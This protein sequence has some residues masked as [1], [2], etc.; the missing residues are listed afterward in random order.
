MAYGYWRAGKSG[1]DAVFHLFFRDEPFAG[2]YAIAAGLA[3]ALDYLEGLRFE[4]DDLEY[5]RAQKGNDGKPLFAGEFLDYLREHNRHPNG[6]IQERYTL[7]LRDFVF[8]NP[9]R[10]LTSLNPDFEAG[11]T[12]TRPIYVLVA[13]S[14]E[15]VPDESGFERRR[16]PLN[17]HITLM[18][19]RYAEIEKY[20][21][22]AANMY[23][24]M[25]ARGEV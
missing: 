15:D 25:R 14:V 5:L 21:A 23:A 17:E 22:E 12:T 18:R 10:L 3:D 2:G 11:A 19:G 6:G 13:D 24:V 8:G 1:D 20:I 4:P 16:L 7:P 9:V